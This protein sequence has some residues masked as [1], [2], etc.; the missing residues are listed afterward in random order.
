MNTI[1]NE[2][3]P[4]TGFMMRLNRRKDCWAGGSA[5]GLSCICALH[6][7]QV[8]SAQRWMPLTCSIMSLTN[9]LRTQAASLPPSQ[10]RASRSDKH[11]PD[12]GHLSLSNPTPQP[13]SP[14]SVA[15]ASFTC[16]RVTLSDR[17]SRA[18]AS[19]RRT[20]ASSWRTCSMRCTPHGNRT[21]WPLV[22]EAKWLCREW[23]SGF[24]RLRQHRWSAAACLSLPHCC[25]RPATEQQPPCNQQRSICIE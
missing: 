2:Q 19:D 25:S 7:R 9:P 21:A 6:R 18:S 22:N 1:S 23:P 3:W 15:L 5:R 13:L 14:L 4:G 20:S 24:T 17:C 10:G 16:S 11:R 12:L 8:G